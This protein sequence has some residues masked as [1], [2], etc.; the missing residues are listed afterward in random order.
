MQRARVM[1]DYLQPA[2][3]LDKDFRV[4]SA[5]S[6]PNDYRG[7]GSGFRLEGEEWERIADIP[8]AKSARRHGSLVERSGGRD[9]RRA[10]NGAAKQ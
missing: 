3:V 8:Q 6:D 2:A 4:E 7:P 9:S 10:T 5:F 1:G